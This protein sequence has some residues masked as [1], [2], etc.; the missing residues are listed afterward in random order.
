[1]RM[2]EVIKPTKP[3]APHEVEAN[4]IKRASDALKKRK[5]ALKVTKARATLQRAQQQLL[6]PSV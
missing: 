1:M 5:A 4:T 6:N 2:H 3:L